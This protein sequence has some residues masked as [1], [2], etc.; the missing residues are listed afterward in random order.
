MK[1]IFVVLTL[2]Y[3]CVVAHAQLTVDS[4]KNFKVEVYAGILLGPS[5]NVKD[6]AKISV[7]ATLR[8]GG[9][10]YWTPQH[11]FSLIGIA[12]VEF[13]E[14]PSASVYYLLAS[15]FK[16]HEK[17]FLTV[18]KLGSP[19]TEMRPLPNSLGGQFEPWTKRQ[20][21]G[22]SFGGKVT[23]QINRSSSVVVGGFLRGYNDA[24]V[25][26]GAKTRF[27]QLGAYY[28]ARTRAFGAAVAVTTKY[29]NQTLVYNYNQNFGSLTVITIPKTAG[30]GLFS[31]VGFTAEKR[32]DWIRAEWGVMKVF[33]LGKKVNALVAVSYAHKTPGLPERVYGYLQICL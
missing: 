18:G 30:C 20:I 15:R 16:L 33:T 19:M 4:L 10:I 11:W 6:S 21:L 27:V 17:L 2:T 22:S 1:K 7:F 25:E 9:N 31:D 8:A 32:W 12:A 29:V 5:I 13:T 23:Y 24:S 26:I 14:K 28:M 3:L